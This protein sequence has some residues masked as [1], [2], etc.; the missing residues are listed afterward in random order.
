[1]IFTTFDSIFHHNSAFDSFWVILHCLCCV[2]FILNDTFF[3]KSLSYLGLALGHAERLILKHHSIKNYE[4]S[5]KLVDMQL[6]S[7]QQDC[8]RK[9]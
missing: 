4:T 5:L 1:M 9:K 3:L 2:Q 7:S 6:H 8:Q